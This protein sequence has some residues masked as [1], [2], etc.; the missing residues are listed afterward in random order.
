MNIWFFIILIVALALA[1]GPISML[2]P[3]P[4]QKRKEN[5][6]L[7]ASQRGVRFTLR[8]PPVLS[9]DI[10]QAIPMPVYYLPP[11]AKAP[12]ETE[13]I[14]M[15]THYEHE[16]NFYQEWDWQT[17]ARPD[18]AICQC[19]AEYLPILPDS[20]IAI[21]QGRLGTCVFWSEK[22]DKETL[23]RLIDMMEKLHRY[24]N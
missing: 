1:L 2:K 6:R 9:T 24:T 21:S 18:D 11:I 20:V 3:S 13:W 8:R 7:Y 15:R 19:L 17:K 22:E 5:L 12:M 16:G 23:A 14:L 10:E 4:A